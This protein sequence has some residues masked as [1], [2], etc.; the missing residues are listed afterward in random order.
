M[1][2]VRV[3]PTPNGSNSFCSAS[4]GGEPP[5]SGLYIG[6]PPAL[7]CNINLRP[8]GKTRSVGD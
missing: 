7:V 4:V 8:F 6:V 5:S 2:C 3:P 1:A